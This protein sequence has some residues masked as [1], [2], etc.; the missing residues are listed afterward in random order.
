MVDLERD[1]GATDRPRKPSLGSNDANVEHKKAKLEHA[2]EPED[3]L[4]DA[5]SRAPS[6]PPKPGRADVY[7][8][9]QADQE[10]EEEEDPRPGAT[11][12]NPAGLGP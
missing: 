7:D 4:M 10:S 2:N 3:E 9:T 12:G 11:T 6:S 5:R 8:L 1:L